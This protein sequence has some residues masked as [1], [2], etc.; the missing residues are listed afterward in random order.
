MLMWVSQFCQLW[1]WNAGHLSEK[2]LYSSDTANIFKEISGHWKQ[3]G[4]SR[5]IQ[6]NPGPNASILLQVVAYIGIDLSLWLHMKFSLW[7]LKN[8]KYLTVILKILGIKTGFIV[9]RNIGNIEFF[10]ILH[11]FLLKKSSEML[12]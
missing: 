10:R 7:L 3:Y 6:G 1:A 8:F 4:V 2:A 9:K 5:A 11:D 12:Q